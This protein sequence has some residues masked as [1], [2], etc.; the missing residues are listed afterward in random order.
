MSG[1]SPDL[2]ARVLAELSREPSPTRAE[3]RSRSRRIAVGGVA[4]TLAVF[5]GLGGV[6]RGSRPLALLAL[7]VG[8]ALLAALGL[9]R[10]A[11]GAPRSMLGRPRAVLAIACLATGPLLALVPL[12]ADALWPAAD[13]VPLHAHLACTVLTLGEGLLPLALFLV[14]RAGSEPV[15]PALSGAA[16]GIA[17]GAWA[18]T[19]AYLRCPHLGLVHMTLAHVAPCIVLA[20]L[21]GALG[22][23][24]LRLGP[25]R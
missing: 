18:T 8:T 23:R 5:F 14:L 19:M 16:L 24:L 20:A 1:P 15:A 21:G 3:H 6:L 17:A 12:V 25:R 10:L 22:A 2:R 7:S 9:T 4:L 11:A 13:P